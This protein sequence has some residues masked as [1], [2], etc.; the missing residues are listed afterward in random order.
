[1]GFSLGAIIL[2][3]YLNYFLVNAFGNYS[4]FTSTNLWSVELE[5]PYQII[6]YL[7]SSVIIPSVVEEYFFRNTICK[8]LTVYGK[9]TAIL[10]SAALFALMHTNAEQI[11]YAFVGGVLLAWI[12]V[13][14]KSIAIPI[15]VHMINN[16]TSAIADIINAGIKRGCVKL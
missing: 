13:E 1:M 10:A 14:T 16:G 4:D 12:Y 7:A 5:H 2:A 15:I 11:I 6:I 9:G 8:A 3:S